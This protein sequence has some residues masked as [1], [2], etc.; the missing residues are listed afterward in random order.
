ML[1]IERSSGRIFTPAHNFM[2]KYEDINKC[3]EVIDVM[4]KIKGWI[5][6]LVELKA[7][8][9]ENDEEKFEKVAPFLLY[10]QESVKENGDLHDEEAREVSSYISSL[11]K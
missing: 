9:L 11:F 8:D 10:I 2:F 5:P 3:I 1:K 4:P 7:L 6:T